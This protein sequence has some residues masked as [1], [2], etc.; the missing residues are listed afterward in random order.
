[1]KEFEFEKQYKKELRR[2][3]RNGVSL[4]EKQDQRRQQK[5]HGNKVVFTGTILDIRKQLQSLV[6]LYG[7]IY[8]KDL[9]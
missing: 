2:L 4:E 5:A 6:S 7:N 1:M 3:Y 9:Y 8:L